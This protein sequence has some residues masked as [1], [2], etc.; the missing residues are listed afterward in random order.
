MPVQSSTCP[1]C[2]GSRALGS[3]TGNKQNTYIKKERE[4]RIHLE[5]IRGGMY[6][7]WLTE[8]TDKARIR[9]AEDTAVRAFCPIRLDPLPLPYSFQQKAEAAKQCLRTQAVQSDPKSH[10]LP[11]LT[12]FISCAE[13][14][15]V[16]RASSATCRA[17]VRT[18]SW[19]S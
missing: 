4:S 8:G 9:C 5:R 3:L 11:N 14:T 2:A 17:A 16:G 1:E 12:T 6:T 10:P 18:G 13:A 7:K 15:E 19:L